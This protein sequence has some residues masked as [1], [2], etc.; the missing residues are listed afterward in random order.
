M[1]KIKDIKEAIAHMDQVRESA[2]RLGSDPMA[3]A[4]I[5]SATGIIK[6]LEW[7]LGDDSDMGFGGMLRDMKAFDSMTNEEVDAEVIKL[8][9]RVKQGEDVMS[10][11]LKKVDERI[12]KSKRRDTD[13]KVLDEIL[14][15]NYGFDPQGTEYDE[16]LDAY[17]GEVYEV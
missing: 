7:V 1:R 16:F 3:V 11:I 12:A 15:L 4:S 6:A 13:Q 9:K 8:E 5:Q 10:Q 14:K 17:K 2:A